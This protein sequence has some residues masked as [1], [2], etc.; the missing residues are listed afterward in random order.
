MFVEKKGS[1]YVSLF[2]GLE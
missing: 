1:L 2:F